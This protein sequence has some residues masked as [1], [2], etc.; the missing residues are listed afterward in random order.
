MRPWLAYKEKADKKHKHT[1]RWVFFGYSFELKKNK[2]KN[3][4][5]L[6]FIRGSSYP[7]RYTIYTI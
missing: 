2:K 6:I 7:E 5:K 3:T 1:K 4:H